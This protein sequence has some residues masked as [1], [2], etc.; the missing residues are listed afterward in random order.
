MWTTRGVHTQGTAG[1]FSCLGCGKPVL[2]VPVTIQL[3]VEVTRADGTLLGYLHSNCK[4][5]WAEKNPS[6]YKYGFPTAP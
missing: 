1:L 2:M 3:T 6:D 5:A 4:A